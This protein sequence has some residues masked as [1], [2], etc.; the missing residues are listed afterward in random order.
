M[1]V[2]ISGAVEAEYTPAIPVPLDGEYANSTALQNMVLPLANR[3]EFIRQGLIEAPFES[4]VIREDWFDSEKI[5]SGSVHGDSGPWTYA[6]SGTAW[7]D[8]VQATSSIVSGSAGML[9][10]QNSSGTAATMQF[11]KRALISRNKIVRV[12]FRF[13][14]P[15]GSKDNVKAQLGM[16]FGGTTAI[17]SGDTHGFGMI[18]DPDVHANFRTVGVSGG[19]Y[20]YTDTGVAPADNTHYQF[21]IVQNLDT[22]DIY[23]NIQGAGQYA[24]AGL[25][26]VGIDLQPD[27]RFGSKNSGTRRFNWDLF[28]LGLIVPR[29]S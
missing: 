10:L 21:D 18:Y 23:M 22:L 19:V 27:C 3:V 12:S 5:G 14:M 25:P 15:T 24:F 8:P 20:S 9:F 6:E 13:N 2:D 29:Y 28:Y 17:G 7:D 26:T 1:P 4:P 11:K 16:F